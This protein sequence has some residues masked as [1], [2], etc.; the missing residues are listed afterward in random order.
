MKARLYA[1]EQFPRPAVECLRNLGY[2]VL[3]VQE[4]RNAG[5]SDSEVLAFAIADSRAVLT[6]NRR[7][8]V[9]LH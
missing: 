9:K 1:D 6:Q 4:A 2:D 5:T 8:F 7:D 3:T